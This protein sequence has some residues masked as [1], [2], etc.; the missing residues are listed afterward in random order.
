[1]PMPMP[2]TRRSGKSLQV[3]RQVRRQPWRQPW[4]CICIC[5]NLESLLIA[6]L[7]SI[8]VLA[9]AVNFSMVAMMEEGGVSRTSIMMNTKQPQKQAQPRA[10]KEPILEILRLANVT[11]LTD[12]ELGSLPSW[13]QVVDRIGDR[14]RMIGLDTCETYRQTVPVADRHVAPSG[15]FSTGTNLLFKLLHQN[16]VIYKQPH[17]TG[18]DWQ[19]NW[20]KHQSPRF[21]HFNHLNAG[22]NNS[23]VFPIV[24]VRDPWTWLQ[25]MCRVR[26]SAHWFHGMS[27]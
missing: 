8:A 3:R 20:G 13:R 1:M 9:V 17:S 22:I 16:C 18:V 5:I 24:M 21:R 2:A 19:V 4:R 12:I 25:S 7:A 14:P 27:Q 11:S 15:M 6:S 23:D 10:N 26:Y